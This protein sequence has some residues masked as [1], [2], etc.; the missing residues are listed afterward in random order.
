MVSRVLRNSKSFS[1]MFLQLIKSFKNISFPLICLKV[2]LNETMKDGVSD[3]SQKLCRILKFVLSSCMRTLEGQK[4]FLN[5]EKLNPLLHIVDIP[6]KH[7]SNI[8][9]LARIL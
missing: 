6:C 3:V 2:C 9:K 7:D 4:P 1:E 8:I 5:C